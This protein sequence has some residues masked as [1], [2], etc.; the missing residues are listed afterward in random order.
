MI[1]EQIEPIKVVARY[2]RGSLVK[3][4]TR[5]FFSNKSRFHVT[6]MDGAAD[7]PIEVTINDLKAVFVVRDFTGDPD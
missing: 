1:K 3:G 6:P 5:D 4:L 2:V 7:K